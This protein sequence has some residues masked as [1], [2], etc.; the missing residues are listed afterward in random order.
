MGDLMEATPWSSDLLVPRMG[1]DFAFYALVNVVFLN[2]LFGII[3]DTFAE[4]RDDKRR[5]EEDMTSCCFVC[6]LPSDA[7]EKTSD[8]ERAP[9]SSSSSVGHPEKRETREGGGG[10]GEPQSVVSPRRGGGGV[11][12]FRHHV[13]H[14][15]NMW[16]YLYFL[17]HLRLKDPTEYTG[18]ESYVADLVARNNLSFFPSGKCVTLSSSSSRSPQPGAATSDDDASDAAGSSGGHPSD[19]SSPSS[20]SLHRSTGGGDGVGLNG[21]LLQQG[22]SSA[23]GAAHLLVDSAAAL[24]RLET[25]L[26]LIKEKLLLDNNS[27]NGGSTTITTTAG[28]ASRLRRNTLSSV[29]AENMHSTGSGTVESATFRTLE[30]SDT[31]SHNPFFPSAAAG[32]PSITSPQPQL[33]LSRPA[34]PSSTRDGWSQTPLV[35]FSHRST[36]T[37]SSPPA[38]PSAS[39]KG[40]V[41]VDEHHLHKAEKKEKNEDEEELS[42]MQEQVKRQQRHLHLY[43]ETV[44]KLL[45]QITM[46][47]QLVDDGQQRRKH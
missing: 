19:V 46:L 40:L 45:R 37:I 25:D 35:L 39:A 12:G 32:A 28:A 38:A 5:K 15:H 42:A 11:G 1:Y 29:G 44:D 6:G 20:S 30:L 47:E 14:E 27:N 9:I 8:D 18:Q 13:R 3:I 31:S 24:H 16:H 36:E 41:A 10:G 23:D 43:A 4:L 17:Y 34:A 22:S 33:Q 2:I 21:S 7:F 26:A